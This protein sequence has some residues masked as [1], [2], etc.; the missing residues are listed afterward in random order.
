M[1]RCPVYPADGFRVGHCAELK[2]PVGCFDVLTKDDS[3]AV[4]ILIP[5]AHHWSCFD[6][7]RLVH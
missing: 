5:N 6:E 1:T 2:V 7:A 3:E 4:P